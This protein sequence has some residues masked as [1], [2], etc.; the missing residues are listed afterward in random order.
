MD[1]QYDA[2]SIRELGAGADHVV[3]GERLDLVEPRPEDLLKR[4][5]QQ[6]GE[7]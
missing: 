6:H 2:L 5:A 7:G 1:R 4:E 3:A